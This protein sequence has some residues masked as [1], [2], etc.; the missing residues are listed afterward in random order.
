MTPTLHSPTD[1]D[2]A[3]WQRLYRGYADYYGMPMSEEILD[4]VWGWI[5][6]PDEPFHCRLARSNNGE[7]IGLMHYRP[8]PSPLRGTRIGFL[9]DLFVDPAHRGSG[10]ADAMLDALEKRRAIMAGRWYAGSPVSTTIGPAP[11]T[12]AAR[13]IP[14]GRPMSWPCRRSTSS[15][16]PG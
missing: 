10:I 14:T 7:A 6:A 1:Q 13:G 12:T 2:R 11:S 3:D 16:H 9:D 8:M 5:H 4:T 15:I